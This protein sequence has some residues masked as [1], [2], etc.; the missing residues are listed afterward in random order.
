MNS[1]ML[2]NAVIA[3]AGW[4]VVATWATPVI[5]GAVTG[6]C[7]CAGDTCAPGPANCTNNLTSTACTSLCQLQGTALV[8]GPKSVTACGVTSFVLGGTCGN[9]CQLPGSPTPTPTA[10]GTVTATPTSTPTATPSVTQTPTNSP[11]PQE[12]DDVLCAD[13]IDN[14]DDGRI[15]CLDAD[16]GAA[17]AC[18][19]KAPLFGPSAGTILIIAGLLGTG[20]AGLARSRRRR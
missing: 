12:N 7:V 9:Q 14:D 17:G 19:L 5:A 20:L 15:D 4:L 13:G 2:Q 8:F 10:T 18:R 16:C 3:T 6:C 11:G 1:R